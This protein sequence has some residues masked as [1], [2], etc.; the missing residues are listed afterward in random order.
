MGG[1]RI[2]PANSSGSFTHL[3]L[4]DG[5]AERSESLNSFPALRKKSHGLPVLQGQFVLALSEARIH[6]VANV[7]RGVALAEDFGLLILDVTVV[8]GRMKSGL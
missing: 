3:V 2:I 4:H 5:G 1:E 7:R 8:A 6:A